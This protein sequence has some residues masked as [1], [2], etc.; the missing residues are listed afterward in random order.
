L[1]IIQINYKSTLTRRLSKSTM[2]R[3]HCESM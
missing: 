2:V 1:K 3:V